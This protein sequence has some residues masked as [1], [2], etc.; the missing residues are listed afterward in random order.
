MSRVLISLTFLVLL[1]LAAF[2]Q[3]AK[4][5]IILDKSQ[6][7][8]H[9]V[10]FSVKALETISILPWGT[11]LE[12]RLRAD[13][14]HLVDDA[15]NECEWQGAIYRRGPF[16]AA[17]EHFLELP[18]GFEF[19][20]EFDLAELYDCHASPNSIYQVMLRFPYYAFST[21]G[22]DL[23]ELEIFD[24]EIQVQWSPELALAPKVL[25]AKHVETLEPPAPA[26]TANTFQNCNTN[27]QNI[28]KASVPTAA[29]QAARGSCLP[30]SCSN[31]LATIWF[32]AYNQNNYNYVK[33]VLSRTQARLNN[34]QA[35]YCNP[36]G[37]GS[38]IYAYVYPT[39]CCTVYLCGLFWSIP[40]ERAETI[41][42][43][44]SHFNINSNTG[45]GTQDY[46]YGRSGCISLAKSN[47]TNACHNADN[48]CYFGAGY[49]S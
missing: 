7:N 18:E 43:E 12:D 32:G 31:S 6:K 40:S 39:Q 36:S 8:S 29:N 45:K 1:S 41:V 24:E 13:L 44:Q 19:S 21:F 37:C 4:L 38:N 30:S 33:D 20:I 47:P 34:G 10:V 14:F 28:I 46:Q 49:T 27:E 17:E 35:S 26:T 22:G 42:H 5:H 25:S 23:I 2:C 48:V 3:A 15:G 11:P 9:S 16:P